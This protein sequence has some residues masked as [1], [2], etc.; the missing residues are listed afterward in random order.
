VSLPFIDNPCLLGFVDRDVAGLISLTVD[1]ERV[2][3]IHV[4]CEP[5]ALDFLREHV[6]P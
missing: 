6:L 3:E 4:Y 5:R 2:T 1:G